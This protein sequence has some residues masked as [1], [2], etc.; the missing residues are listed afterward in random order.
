M[1]SF[2][3]AQYLDDYLFSYYRCA[4]TH[5]ALKLPRVKTWS[6]EKV[7]KQSPDTESGDQGEPFL[8]MGGKELLNH[9]SLFIH[10]GDWC[11]CQLCSATLL[12]CSSAWAPVVLELEELVYLRKEQL[13]YLACLLLHVLRAGLP[14]NPQV[15]LTSGFSLS[16]DKCAER[17]GN[18]WLNT[19]ALKSDLYDIIPN[20]LH[21]CYITL[22]RSLKI[23]IIFSIV[24]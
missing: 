17:W 10:W 13:V 21:T 20:L 12:H 3:L 18:R 5:M 11:L 7:K 24:K 1:Y 8:L 2:K 16:P 9:C 15:Q 23:P 4:M 19:Q 14:L 22:G 6:L